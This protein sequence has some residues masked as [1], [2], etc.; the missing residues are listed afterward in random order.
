MTS[1]RYSRIFA[2]I[3]Y[4]YCALLSI[5]ALLYTINHDAGFHAIL[6]IPTFIISLLGMYA[7]LKNW[8][9]VERT[10]NIVVIIALSTFVLSN[11]ALL[12]MIEPDVV[13]MLALIET[14][15]LSSMIYRLIDINRLIKQIGEVQSYGI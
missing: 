4:F 1:Q 6:F 10:I 12:F 8:I 11:I 13:I 15:L 7:I 3:R 14:M 5:L 9:T 2:T